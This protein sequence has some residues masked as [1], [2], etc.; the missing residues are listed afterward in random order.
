MFPIVISAH[1]ASSHYFKSSTLTNHAEQTIII[2][3]EVFLAFDNIAD[4]LEKI[5]KTCMFVLQFKKTIA[6]LVKY[7]KKA[8][9]ITPET[10]I[11]LSDSKAVKNEIMDDLTKWHN[12]IDYKLN[13]IGT[14]QQKII[15]ATKSFI[16]CAN[17]LHSV[18]KELESQISKIAVALDK[19]A[20]NIAS[21][22]DMLLGGTCSDY[23]VE[24]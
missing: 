17:E 11:Q 8:T 1:L 6:T 19:I 4:R 2:H 24:T 14:L 21:Y 15:E 22:Q 23:T 20:S 12:N 5:C 18:A 7:T 10:V 13:I 16:N 9:K 3:K